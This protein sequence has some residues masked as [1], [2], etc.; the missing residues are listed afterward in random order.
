LMLA[1]VMRGTEL[2]GVAEGSVAAMKSVQFVL[3]ILFTAGAWRLAR[4]YVGQRAGLIVAVLVGANLTAFHH[5]VFILSDMLYACLSIW[6]LVLLAGGYNVKRWVGGLC[7]AELAWLSRPA[8]LSLGVGALLWAIAGRGVDIGGKKQRMALSVAVIILGVLPIAWLVSHLAGSAENYFTWWSS[9]S[10]QGNLIAGAL[11]LF[12]KWGPGVV[13]TVARTVLNVETAGIGTVFGVAVSAVMVI[14]WWL[15]MRKR[16]ALP[17]LYVLVY[18]GAMTIWANTAVTRFYLPILPMLF[19][20]L[21][22]AL[23]W[24]REKYNAHAGFR[25]IV[26]IAMY[27]VLGLT[28]L[29]LLMY[30]HN[31]GG[32]PGPM[33]TVR[34]GYIYCAL[35][36]L[37]LVVAIVRPQIVLR[38]MLN[39]RW[40]TRGVMTV[41]V[42]IALVYLVGYAAL[43][44]R[45][46]KMRP[47]MLQGW[48]PY[49]RMGKW[50][51]QHDDAFGP[52]LT[53]QHA[54]VHLASG[55]V[56]PPM[57]QAPQEKLEQLQD[58]YARGVLVINQPHL[59]DDVADV[60][61]RQLRGLLTKYP[62]DFT[63]I[64]SDESRAEEQ[65]YLYGYRMNMA[66]PAGR[67][68]QK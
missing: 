4:G 46:V 2:L 20:Y 38:L 29:P 61:N 9:K 31:S 47:P 40:G 65:Y 68:M 49:Y 54:I 32:L 50:L 67:V 60:N 10:G 18:V 25:R 64:A 53:S 66:G 28:A 8:G 24:L 62:E 23:R 58:G 37:A 41:Y 16:R 22:V 33:A 30:W 43:E 39:S 63:L 56:M 36:M 57:R 5:V 21:I 42:G 27:P 3:A 35:A 15:T 34:N 19:V 45:M 52:L 44:H 51:R 12:I 48:Q 6:A 11:M 14:G 59:S 1:G 7:L 13:I 55:I 26:H 17:E